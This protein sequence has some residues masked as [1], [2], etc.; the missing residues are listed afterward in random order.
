VTKVR[1]LQR[2][3]EVERRD[4]GFRAVDEIGAISVS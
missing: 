1:Q 3:S 2:V 4:S